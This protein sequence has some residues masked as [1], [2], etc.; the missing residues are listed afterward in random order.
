MWIR[1]QDGNLLV[2]C[3]ALGFTKD[4]FSIVEV[5]NDNVLILGKYETLEQAEHVMDMISHSVSL[6]S[7]GYQVGVFQMPKEVRL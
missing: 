2:Y 6:K 7:R 3:Q 5:R 4:D 1:S